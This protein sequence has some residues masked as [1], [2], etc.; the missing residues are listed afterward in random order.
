[1]FEWINFAEKN[2]WE[3]CHL[4]WQ[5]RWQHRWQPRWLVKTLQMTISSDNNYRWQHLNDNKKTTYMTKWQHQLTITPDNNSHDNTDDN[6]DNIKWQKLR[7]T[8]QMLS[9]KLS[10]VL[11][12]RLSFMSVLSPG[13][14]VTWCC[15]LE[16]LS[17]G[18]VILVAIWS[19]YHME[20][21]SF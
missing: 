7:M 11:S 6:P 10:S 12:S 19:C 13:V 3:A 18:V 21:L 5:L 1:M 17:L 14:V 15:H 2:I 20:F 9:S 8:T 16:L 4:R